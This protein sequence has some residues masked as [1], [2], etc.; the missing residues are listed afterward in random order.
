M[1]LKFLSVISSNNQTR[2]FPVSKGRLFH[3]G[4]WIG[5]VD[6]GNGRHAKILAQCEYAPTPSPEPARFLRT[7]APTG[8][9][10]VPFLPPPASAEAILV[11]LSG[12]LDN[13]ACLFLAW[14]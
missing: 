1:H 14:R 7:R 11:L 4:E 5:H 10:T 13:H 6:V 2:I 12:R 3:V 8:H 9:D